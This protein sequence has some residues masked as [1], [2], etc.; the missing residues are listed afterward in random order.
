MPVGFRRAG[1][2]PARIPAIWWSRMDRRRAARV[3]RA[4]IDVVRTQIATGN[5]PA[6]RATLERLLQEGH[7][8][9]Q[10]VR[11]IAVAILCEMND[12][13]A[14]ERNFDERRFTEMLD[15]LPEL[16]E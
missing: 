12:M 13:M 2:L 5:P 9:K 10:A 4:L 7:S 8:R 1:R 16:P 11:L 3:R 15:A 14:E 6:T